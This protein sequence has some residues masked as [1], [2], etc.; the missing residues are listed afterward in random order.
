[1]IKGNMS[2]EIHYEDG[3]IIIEVSSINEAVSKVQTRVCRLNSKSEN[4]ILKRHYAKEVNNMND[5]MVATL[6]RTG[7]KELEA[8]IEACEVWGRKTIDKLMNEDRNSIIT[9]L[10]KLGFK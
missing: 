4:V 6:E 2:K 3:I 9:L 5:A 7:N 8:E 10:T 1:M